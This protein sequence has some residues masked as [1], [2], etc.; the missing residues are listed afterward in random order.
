MEN[1]LPTLRK[2]SKVSKVTPE[3]ITD[4]FMK[5]HQ[6]NVD[7]K[8]IDKCYGSYE[9][10]VGTYKFLI[11]ETPISSLNNK[12]GRVTNLQN[13]M[14]ALK[15]PTPLYLGQGLMDK[16]IFNILK[17]SEPLTTSNKWLFDVFSL[18]VA[19]AYFRNYFIKSDCLSN[20]K[21]ILFEAI[22]AFYLGYDH[23]AI[24]SLFPVFEGGLRNLQNK[25]LGTN[26][27]IVKADLFD[28]GIRQMI[29]KW[30]EKNCGG[31]DWYPG[32]DIH[33][34]VQIDFFTHL[35]NQCDV[36][37]ATLIFFNKVLYLS[38]DNISDEEKHNFNRHVIIHL[39]KSNFEEPSNFIR[40][41]LALT[42]LTFMES[43]Y[44]EEVPFFWNGIN[45][46]DKIISHYIRS[47]MDRDFTER[48][49]SLTSF[50]IDLYHR[51]PK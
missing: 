30:G 10:K 38:S 47:K 41:F 13:K 31:Y 39:L 17:E 9:I 43:L 49:D 6:Q 44:N 16:D 42:H 37:N 20:Y 36:M 8:W 23:I 34:E 40:V 2:L 1:Y 22:E 15:I 28:K 35:N 26:S 48:R 25:I 45:E 14:V 27:S 5:E 24:M 33:Q 19:I 51:S 50:G 3:I 32:K 18:E 21:A 12:W 11:T 7:I 29:I 46:N 4:F